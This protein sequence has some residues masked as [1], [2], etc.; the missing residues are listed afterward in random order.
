MTAT[1]SAKIYEFPA[2][3]RFAAAGNR[4]ESKSAD[5]TSLRGA[6][7]VAA[8]SVYGGSWYHDA[9]IEEAERTRKN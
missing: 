9:A 6:K 5:V 4:D 7:G 8:K 3:G 2:R 1:G